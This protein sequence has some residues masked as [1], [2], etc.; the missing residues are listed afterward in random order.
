MR[1]LST[2]SRMLQILSQV[3]SPRFG[4][5]EKRAWVV[6]VVVVI[7]LIRCRLLFRTASGK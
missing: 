6:V 1:N 4:S 2:K 3:N 7:T 5:V